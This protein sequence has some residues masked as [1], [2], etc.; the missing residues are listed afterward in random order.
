MST[1]WGTGFTSVR[2]A[3]RYPE[4][5]AMHGPGYLWEGS[6]NRVP[7]RNTRSPTCRSVIPDP[8]MSTTPA[9]WYPGEH[10]YVAAGSRAN[11]P[12]LPVNAQR[13][14]PWLT[15][16]KTVLTPTWPGPG[17]GTSMSL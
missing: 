6:R 2:A 16:E 17:S 8:M 5:D 11:W 9:A 14:V 15:P 1:F 13:S 10:G 7:E 3:T 12:Y 4:C